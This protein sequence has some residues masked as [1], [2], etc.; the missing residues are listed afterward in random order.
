LDGVIVVD[1]APNWTSH[2]VVAKMRGI[3]GT[4]S[5]GH[6]GTLDPIA[7]GVLP[8]M[9]G[10]AT[11]LARYFG[12]A[13]KSYEA[14]VRFGFSTTTYD[15]EGDPTSPPVD[16]TVTV[17]QIEACLATM[18]GDIL[19]MPPAVSAK[20]INGVPAYKLA[21]K[22][23]PVELK[24]VPVSIYELTLV[25]VMSD[26]RARLTVRC[27]AGTY[28]RSLAHDLGAALGCG[29]HVEEL[30]R[31]VSGAFGLSQAYTLEAL[32][33]LKEE[34]RL[35]EAILPMADLLPEFPGVFVDD[36]AERQ[37]RQGRDFGVSAFRANAGSEYVKA[38]GENGT[39]VAIGKIAL[40]HVY[41]PEVVFAA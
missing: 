2:D 11:R 28:V 27:S 26:D 36:L 22:N 37:I 16:I 29:A 39:L 18:R 15:R 5:V 1:K 3:A 17:E 13:E 10:Q 31:T 6:L 35:S 20:K 30:R 19:Q 12:K 33:H 7:T 34:G 40:P 4:R 24:A 14:V 21:R 8:V 32:Q 23:E 25:E 41:H 38:I 9:I